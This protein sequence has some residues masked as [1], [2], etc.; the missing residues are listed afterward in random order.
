MPISPQL[1]QRTITDNEV[2]HLDDHNRINEYLNSIVEGQ[3][4]VPRG[5][6][7]V[8]TAYDNPDIVTHEGSSYI[9]RGP[10]TGSE[11]LPDNSNLDWQLLA[12]VGAAGATT[13]DGLTD[14]NA[15]TP[16]DGSALVWRDVGGAWVPEVIS[17]GVTDHGA[18][19][20]LGDD[21]HPQYALDAE[22]GVAN[23]IATLDAGG[24]VPASQLG[25]VPSGAF[26]G[27][28]AYKDTTPQS[29][30]NGTL[31]AI[32]LNLESFDPDGFHDNVT[33]PS[34]FTC[35]AGKA[36]KY[37]FV[38]NIRFAPNTTGDRNAYFRKNGT[39]YYSTTLQRAASVGTSATD[40]PALAIIDLIAGDYV[41]MVGVQD[42]GGALDVSASFHGTWAGCTYEGA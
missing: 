41:E 26:V 15:P 42:S 9:A 31:T 35:P 4:G 27:A 12:G 6:W 25:N 23:G 17:G 22:K 40:V 14:V 24:D 20:G 21:D 19:T 39:T 7:D 32:T 3:P 10:S 37:L 30:A 13:L 28:R 16:A 29:L 36:G 5:T 18:L 2:V 11:P 33:N 34:R 8:A 38:G 1:P